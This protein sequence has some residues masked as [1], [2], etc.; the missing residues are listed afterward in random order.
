MES[1]NATRIPTA[2]EFH[3]I[4]KDRALIRRIRRFAQDE[5]ADWLTRSIR[6]G[7]SFACSPNAPAR[8]PFESGC[9]SPSLEMVWKSSKNSFAVSLQIERMKKFHDGTMELPCRPISRP[10]LASERS[11]IANVCVRAAKLENRKLDSR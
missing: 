2:S 1:L 10:V 5:P 11:L 4:R 6:S 3:H 9:K 7:S 8:R